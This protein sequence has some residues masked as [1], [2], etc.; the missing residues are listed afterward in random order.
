MKAILFD[1][2]NVIITPP[3]YGANFTLE[4]EGLSNIDVS[5]FFHGVFLECQKGE[6][7]L[8]EELKPF[9][10]KWGYKKTADEF[11]KN[12]FD[13]ENC[14]NEKMVKKIQEYRKSGIICALATRQ[15]KYRLAYIY[16]V[17]KLN[18]IVDKTYASCNIGY[19]KPQREYFEYI[20]ND[21]KF[22]PEKVLF[23][24]NELSNVKGAQELGINAEVY[25]G[26]ENFENK[27]RDFYE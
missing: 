6:K 7:D 17:M 2:D 15:E 1:V 27:M 5:E 10:D 4:S 13:Y 12:W 8:K 21:L 11:L 25:E 20:L 19:T 14:I 23:W 22:E 3:G 18:G 9:L 16:D 26:F 24:D